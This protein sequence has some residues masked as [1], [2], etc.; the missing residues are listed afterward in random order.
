M[1]QTKIRPINDSVVVRILDT[2]EDSDIIVRPD[3]KY[4]HPPRRAL[5]LAVG[6]GRKGKNGKRLPMTVKEG[7]IVM[8][9][10]HS[11]AGIEGGEGKYAKGD[12][13]VLTEVDIMAI[14]EEGDA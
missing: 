7:D 6:P 13:V 2:V 12:E 9:T 5:V 14:L 3:M 10:G 11:G 1:P 8:V 4:H